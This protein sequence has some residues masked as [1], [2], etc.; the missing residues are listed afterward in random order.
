MARRKT[1]V[2]AGCP[3][4][5]LRRS[6]RGIA[7]VGEARDI[8]RMDRFET[9]RLKATRLAHDD[10]PDLVQLH[11]DSEVSRFIG[12]VRTPAA[13]AAYLATNLRHWADHG[14]GLWTL[15]A[16]DG[17]FMGRAG[18]RYVDLED[19]PELEVAYTFVRSAWGQGVGTEVAQA[20]VEIWQT[21]CSDRSLVGIVMKGNLPSERVL[22]KAGFAYERNAVFRDADCGVFRRTR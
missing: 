5:A 10:L 17:T 12:G 8:P 3:N 19:V 20:L 4:R 16:H 11:L 2:T 21:R 13:T 1:R 6:A 9:P 22:L 18:L 14:V 15:R 7:E